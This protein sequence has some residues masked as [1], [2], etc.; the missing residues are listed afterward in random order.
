M[1]WQCQCSRDCIAF[2]LRCQAR[3]SNRSRRS[4]VVANAAF[5]ASRRDSLAC[6][7][8]RMETVP[9]ARW[10]E[11][12]EQAVAAVSGEEMPPE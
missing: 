12:R 5:T 9:K 3:S 4:V 11:S 7:T 6:Q 10:A 2:R 1:K 8:R